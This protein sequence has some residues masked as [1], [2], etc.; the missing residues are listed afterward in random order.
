MYSEPGVYGDPNAGDGAI[1]RS[2][3]MHSIAECYRALHDMENA[4]ANFEKSYLL[5]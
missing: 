2:N 3:T 4:C 1:Q 5:K